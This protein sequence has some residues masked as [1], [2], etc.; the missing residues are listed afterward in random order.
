MPDVVVHISIAEGAAERLAPEIRRLL[1]PEV[2]RF[3]VMAP[4]LF[5]AF[6]FFAP[7]FRH[8]VHKRSEA[9][10]NSRPDALLM[11][12]A[13]DCERPE[14]FS[15]L[16]GWLCHYAA[17]STLHPLVNALRGDRGYMH[18]AIEHKLE[19]V[20]LKRQGKSLKDVMAL[21]PPFPEVPEA[22]AALKRVCGW[23]DDWD[24]ISYRHTKLQYWL[25]KDRLG[26][27]NGLLGWTRGAPASLS[28]R[29][30]LADKLD[31]S[32]FAALEA[33]A[34]GRAARLMTAAY[35][36]RAGEIDA[37]ELRAVIGNR[38][39]AGVAVE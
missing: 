2:F 7:H 24:R 15:F 33:Q 16:C 9:V 20:E 19:V 28:Y 35:R 38:N 32:P 3:A 12:L 17:D 27:L 23:D 26:L 18:M 30:R 14:A 37:G 39:Y 13:A 34:V 21:L 29:T 25:F 8:G 5:F 36:Y 6:R 11:A 10:H 1:R 22:R 31:L 4:D